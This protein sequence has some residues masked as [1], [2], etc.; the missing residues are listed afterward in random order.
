MAEPSKFVIIST[1]QGELTA[2]VMKSHLESEGI[3]VVL[4]YESAG[5]IYGLAVNGL[6]AVKILVPKELAEE[7]K[8]IIEPGDFSTVEE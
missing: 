4:E 8:R 7:A 6:G 1:V 3:P 5:R 2:N